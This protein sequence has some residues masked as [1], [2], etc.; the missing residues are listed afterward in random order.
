[1][2]ESTEIIARVLHEHD[3]TGLTC[4]DHEGICCP[5][6]GCRHG[7][8]REE[9]R[10]H[11]PKAI[12]AGLWADE[13]EPRRD[14]PVSMTYPPIYAKGRADRLPLPTVPVDF[15]DDGILWLV[16]TSVFW[17]RGFAL[18]VSGEG[19]LV[20]IGDGREPI[21][22]AD[23]TL[24]FE[25][26]EA[27]LAR[28]RAADAAEGTPPPVQPEAW[29]AEALEAAAADYPREMN[30][31]TFRREAASTSLRDIPTPYTVPEWLKDRAA[32]IRA[33]MSR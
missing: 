19:G 6:K 7:M 10:L 30:E 11:L 24:K 27:V 17:P 13:P 29:Y 22:T 4:Y 20:L 3:V 32:R 33:R 16:N 5:A 31:E 26:V 12:L 28:L 9:A 15:V 23:P 21:V 25:A 14:V 8:T 1:M 18:A 2:A